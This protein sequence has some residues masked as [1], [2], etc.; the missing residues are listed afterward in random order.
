MH[1]VQFSLGE[2]PDWAGTEA[3]DNTID[4]TEFLGTLLAEDPSHS[5]IIRGY[6]VVVLEEEHLSLYSDFHST[7][8]S[9]VHSPQKYKEQF[10]FMQFDPN[11]HSPNQYHGFSVVEGLKEQFMVCTQLFL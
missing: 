2:Q 6:C 7:F 3:V 9:F 10:A 8:E 1:R 5:L 4:A 11:S